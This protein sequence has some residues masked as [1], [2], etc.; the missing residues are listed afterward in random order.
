VVAPHH[1]VG[2]EPR[3]E[4]LRVA[5][6]LDVAGEGGRRLLEALR[7]GDV[8]DSAVEECVIVS[9]GHRIAYLVIAGPAYTDRTGM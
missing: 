1:R 9:L 8:G 6:G 3:A 7:A 2:V 5:G 4:P